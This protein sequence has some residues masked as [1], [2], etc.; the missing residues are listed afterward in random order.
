M[1]CSYV[2]MNNQVETLE[3]RKDDPETQ[4]YATGYFVFIPSWLG[5]ILIDLKYG[6]II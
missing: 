1:L 3:P 6:P 2:H 5:E 4:S